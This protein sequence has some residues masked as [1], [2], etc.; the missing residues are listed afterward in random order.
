MTILH[1]KPFDSLGDKYKK[2]L[3]DQQRESLQSF[4]DGQRADKV[5][6]L[7]EFLF[8][9]IML[10]IA[11]PQNTDDGIDTLNQSVQGNLQGY[12]Y[13]PFYDE[14]P[15]LPDWLEDTITRMDPDTQ[16]KTPRVSVCQCV[17]RLV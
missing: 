2:E 4:C 8:E 13:S 12:L 9:C 7:M 15:L 11:I 6:V 1:R 3:S 17:A 14:E 10:M 5:E 16:D